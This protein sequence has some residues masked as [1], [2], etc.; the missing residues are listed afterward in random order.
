[1]KSNEIIKRQRKEKGLTQ[2]DLGKLIGVSK[3]TIQKYESGEIKNLKSDT[4]KKLSE[5]LD[6]DANILIFGIY[7]KGE[8][9]TRLKSEVRLLDA[10]SKYYGNK[11][12]ELLSSFTRLS[13]DDQLK[14]IEYSELLLL[15]GRDSTR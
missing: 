8:H 14:V 11:S 3:A 6:I 15:S 12:V 13:G 7:D 2:T 10:I 5:I 4:I 1:M 9:G